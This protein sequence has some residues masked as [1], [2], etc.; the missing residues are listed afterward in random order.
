MTIW[1]DDDEFWALTAPFLFDD[2]RLDKAPGEIEFLLSLAQAGKQMAVLDLGCGVGRHSLELARRGYR[3]TGVDRTGYYLDQAREKAAA[4][5][6]VVEFFEADM[7]EFRRPQG[8]D[9]ALNLFTTFG[10]F[11]DASQNMRVLRNIYDSL[12]GGGLFIIEMMGKEIL[13]R[14]FR[15]RNWSEHGGVIWLEER[16]VTRNWSWLVSRWIFVSGDRRVEYEFGHWS[17]SA[18]E[19]A[20]MLR[21]AGFSDVTIYGGLDGRPYDH[22]AERLTAVARK[23]LTE[24][25]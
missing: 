24:L 8:F 2:E 15:Q 17:Y 6:L 23:Q 3:V 14:I 1:H 25:R 20:Q 7:R 16:K 12:R 5:G 21:E 9:M 22:N 10:Y 18:V 19:L 13:P 11:E 4:D